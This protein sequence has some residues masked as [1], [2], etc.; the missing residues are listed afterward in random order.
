MCGF[1]CLTR[2]NKQLAYFSFPNYDTYSFSAFHDTILLDELGEL[3][4]TVRNECNIS[5][6]N[7]FLLKY[8]I[9]NLYNVRTRDF[10]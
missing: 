10:H 4:M 8:K 3:S 2:N 9:R 6:H 7:Y 1:Y 5:K